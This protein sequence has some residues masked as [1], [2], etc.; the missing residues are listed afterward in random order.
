LTP[1]FLPPLSPAPSPPL[2][3]SAPPPLPP[4]MPRVLGG[5]SSVT[6]LLALVM[7]L[8][9]ILAT[10]LGTIRSKVRP[11]EKWSTCLMAANQIVSQIYYYRLRTDKYDVNKPSGGEEG[12]EDVSP[13]KKQALAR[14]DFVNTAADIYSNAISTEV[15]KGGA[16]KMDKVAKLQHQREGDRNKFQTILH[17]HVTEYLYGKKMAKTSHEKPK[18][19]A[20]KPTDGPLAGGKANP[21]KVLTQKEMAKR[22]AERKK[23]TEKMMEGGKAEPEHE[24]SSDLADD[25]V[26]QMDIES[27]ID[28][29]VRPLTDRCERR[30][31][32]V[33]RRFNLLEALALI[34]NTSG[35]VL[36]IMGF[37]DWVAI[38]V[39]IASVAMALNDYFY[40]PAQLAATNRAV[41]DLH[42]LIVWWDSLSLVQRKTPA[43]KLRCANTVENAVL[44]L[45]AAQTAVSPALPNQEAEADDEEEDKKK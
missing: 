35:A 22:L 16:L 29:R 30:A 25:L 28:C 41:Q 19:S 24:P 40:V 27:Y 37:A 4:M 43:V 10:F 8:L 6:D 26:S 21:K 12:E 1:P 20:V 23:A 17:R 39:A 18:G 32:T 14:L 33:S 42:N 13:K 36:A 31:P 2:P 44:A 34:A 3:P 38:T 7:V 9:P 45:C 15:S 5:V 11:R